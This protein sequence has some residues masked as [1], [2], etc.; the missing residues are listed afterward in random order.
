[1]IREANHWPELLAAVFAA[2]FFLG[3]ILASSGLPARISGENALIAIE[4][5]LGLLLVALAIQMLMTGLAQYVSN[6]Y[7]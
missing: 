3:L 7:G 6:M 4:R 2:W 1:M 5:L